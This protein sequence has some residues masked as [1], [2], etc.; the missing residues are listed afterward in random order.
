MS[1]KYRIRKRADGM[2]DVVEYFP[3]NSWTSDGMT[4][5]RET[6]AELI[7][8]LEVMLAD[9]RGSNVFD[10]TKMLKKIKNKT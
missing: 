10:E 2:F 7:K 8:M 6:K 5:S 3:P 1:W 4:D 9:C